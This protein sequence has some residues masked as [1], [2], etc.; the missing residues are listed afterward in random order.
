MT[1]HTYELEC[2]DPVNCPHPISISLDKIS[3]LTLALDEAERALRK[4]GRHDNQCA[5]ILGYLNREDVKCSCELGEA[6]KRIRS[7]K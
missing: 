1:T 7:G 2:D 3:S 5:T 6:I 4:Y